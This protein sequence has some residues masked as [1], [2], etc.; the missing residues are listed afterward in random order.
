[1]EIRQISKSFASVAGYILMDRKKKE[2]KVAD[3]TYLGDLEDEDSDDGPLPHD[4]SFETVIST[5]EEFLFGALE[6]A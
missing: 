2:V 5:D 1:M 4:A 6:A 3:L